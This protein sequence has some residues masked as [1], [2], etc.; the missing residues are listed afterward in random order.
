LNEKW[1]SLALLPVNGDGD[2]KKDD[3]DEYYIISISDNDFI[4]QNGMLF[5]SMDLR[6]S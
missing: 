5:R 1:E 2:D 3:K 6:R 4:T